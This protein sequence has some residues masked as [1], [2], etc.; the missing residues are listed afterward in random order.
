L[1]AQAGSLV[2]WGDE[3]VEA[4]APTDQVHIIGPGGPPAEGAGA[5]VIGPVGPGEG[6]GEAA[7]EDQV[8]YVL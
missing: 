6:Q 1:A 4:P 3:G 2:P 7:R 8:G 5:G